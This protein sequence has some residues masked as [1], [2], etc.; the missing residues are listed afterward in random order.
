[1]AA[2]APDSIH[3]VTATGNQIRGVARE[4]GVEFKTGIHALAKQLPDVLEDAENDLT[5]MVRQLLAEQL[6]QLR[7]CRQRNDALHA[8]IVELASQDPAY[9]RLLELPGV[10]P[11]VASAYLASIGNGHQFHKG[12]EVSAWL[13]LVPRQSGT[14]NG[15]AQGLLASGKPPHRS[16]LRWWQDQASRHDQER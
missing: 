12:R 14:R 2:V 6:E 8:R 1:M 3:Q 7:H 5:P 4:Y 13:G 16:R 10:G 11:V 9:G 15:F